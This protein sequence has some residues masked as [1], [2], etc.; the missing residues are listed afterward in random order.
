MGG[1]NSFTISILINDTECQYPGPIRSGVVGYTSSSYHDRAVTPGSISG[2]CNINTAGPLKL[3][4]KFTQ[5]SSSR[6]MYDGYNY[7]GNPLVATFHVEEL[8]SN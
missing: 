6:N 1:W 3:S 8:C 2:I 7:A 5:Y 4:T